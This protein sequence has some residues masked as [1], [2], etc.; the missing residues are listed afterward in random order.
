MKKKLN[1]W[2]SATIVAIIFLFVL[3]VLTGYCELGYIPLMWYMPIA[4][5]V[6]VIMIACV[7]YADTRYKEHERERRNHEKRMRKYYKQDRE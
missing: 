2:E 3:F 6:S 7:Y 1:S 4:G 5:V